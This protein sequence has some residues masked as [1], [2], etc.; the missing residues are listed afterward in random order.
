MSGPPRLIA[1]EA[2][3]R[4]AADGASRRRPLLEPCDT[5]R[6]GG[7]LPRLLAGPPAHGGAETFEQ[8]LARLGHLP[9]RCPEDIVEMVHQAGLRGRGGS[10][11]PVGRKMAAVADRGGDPLVVVNA[12]ESEPAS[13]KD[14]LLLRL[15]P[16]LLLDGAAVAAAATGAGQAVI[17]LH[18]GDDVLASALETAL[19]ERTSTPFDDPTF[20]VAYGPPKFVAGESSAIVSFLEGGLAKP[21]HAHRSSTSGVDGRPTLIQNAETAAHLALIG[22]G[23][24]DWFRQAGTSR[25]PGSVLVTL[26]GAVA[27]PGQVLELSG[28]RPTSDLLTDAGRLDRPP[29]AVLLGGYGGAWV[30]GERAWDVPIYPDMLADRHLPFGCGLLAVL[31]HGHC[32]IAETARLLTYLADE[33]AQ[34]CGAC[35]FGLPRLA[36]TMQRLAAGQASRAELRRFTRRSDSIVGRGACGHPDGAVA[37]AASALDTF[38]GDVALHLTGRPCPPHARRGLFPIPSHCPTWR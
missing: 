35:M 2:R 20:R 29:Q 15:R 27:S 19:L 38:A 17:Y 21:R 25:W 9:R 12:A 6:S 33:S 28:P 13:M 8:H 11:F 7:Q 30:E 1:R 10:G 3:A 32:G 16:Q 22:R 34:Q 14:R 26:T 5:A 24:P 4:P 37:M 18:S 23:G 36:E 31:P